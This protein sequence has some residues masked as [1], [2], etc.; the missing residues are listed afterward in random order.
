MLERVEKSVP[1]IQTTNRATVFCETLRQNHTGVYG[2]IGKRLLDITLVILSLPFVLAFVLLAACIIK[3][4]GGP[5]IYRQIRIGRYGQPFY[6]YK[7]RS[8]VANAD[9][10][11]DK[12]LATDARAREEWQHSQK[13]ENDPRVTSIGR[14]LRRLS[15]DELPQ[16]WN[17]L[18]GDMSLVG[19]R[20]FLPAQE[21]MYHGIHYYD[22]R[23]GLTGPWQIQS[24]AKCSFAARAKFDDAY[25]DQVSLWTDLKIMIRTIEV[26][27]R[28]RGR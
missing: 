12:L 10:E 14:L 20:P 11:L 7:L 23:P 25:K 22:L 28:A 16:L 26:M 19:P 3:L 17:V 8:M 1:D 13:L 21:S 18:R 24:R 5:A 15:L 27:L 6:C 4:D 9:R 2:S